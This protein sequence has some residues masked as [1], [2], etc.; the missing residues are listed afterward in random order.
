[1]VMNLCTGI[2]ANQ[3]IV[4]EGGVAADVARKAQI[5]HRHE[6]AVDADESKPEMQL[7]ERLVHHPANHFGH[8]EIGAGKNS[9]NRRHGHHEMEVGN[10]EVGG[11]QIS[12][13]GRLRQEESADSAADEHRDEAEAERATRS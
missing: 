4:G 7:S 11:V 10:D 13:D 1:M 12:V 8:P 3:I 6:N 2:S 5:M 9:E